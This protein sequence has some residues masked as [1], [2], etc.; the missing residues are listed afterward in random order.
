ML[1]WSK[2]Q[3]D[4]NEV[5]EYWIVAL[6]LSTPKTVR[7]KRTKRAKRKSQLQK[8]IPGWIFT[9]Q[10]KTQSDSREA[11]LQRVQKSQSYKSFTKNQTRRGKVGNKT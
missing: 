3:K 10:I 1:Q 7:V 8:Y 11:M 9:S 5:L 2:R 6:G 4:H